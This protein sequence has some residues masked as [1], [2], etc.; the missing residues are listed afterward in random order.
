[1]IGVVGGEC[2]CVYGVYGVMCVSYECAY[3]GMG[4]V[5]CHMSV[6]SVTWFTSYDVCYGHYFSIFLLF[7]LFISFFS[8]FTF[9]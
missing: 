2:L 3:D 9:H 7:L 8:C 5:W 6:H 1:M 4:V